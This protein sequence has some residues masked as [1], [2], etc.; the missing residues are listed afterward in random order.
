MDRVSAS[1]PTSHPTPSRH[2]EPPKTRAAIRKAR[3][4]ARSSRP[5]PVLPQELTRGPA[6]SHVPAVAV[7]VMPD[8]QDDPLGLD[9]RLRKGCMKV[10]PVLASSDWAGSLPVP[11]YKRSCQTCGP[12]RSEEAE[13]S[14]W[15]HLRPLETVWI[16]LFDGASR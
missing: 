4:S 7:P 14:M 5:R 10:G 1:P 15:R 12:I 9:E 2:Q 11:C 13:M 6:W 8:V 3:A 16:N